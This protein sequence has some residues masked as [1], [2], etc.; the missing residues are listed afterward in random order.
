M[1]GYSPRLAME[2]R[3]IVEVFNDAVYQFTA[4]KSDKETESKLEKI[5][6]TAPENELAAAQTGLVQGKAIA[7]GMNLTKLLGDLPGNICTPTYLAEQALELG[8]KYDKL[9]R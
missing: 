5:T 3:Q 1:R 2:I 6:I 4:H 8:K 9:G 7:E